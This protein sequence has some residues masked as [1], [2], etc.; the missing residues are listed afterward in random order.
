MRGFAVGIGQYFYRLL[1]GRCFPNFMERT[2]L[3]H[4]IPVKQARYIFFFALALPLVSS[5]QDTVTYQDL[6][7]K[8]GTHFYQGTPF[9]GVM[10]DMRK[11]F[12]MGLHYSPVMYELKAGKLHGKMR[13]YHENGGMG[14]EGGYAEGKEQ[15]TWKYY[16]YRGNVTREVEWKDGIM[17]NY[18]SSNC[19]NN[20][21]PVC[22]ID[23]RTYLNACWAKYRRIEI[24][25][26]DACQREPDP[27]DYLTWPIQ[28]ICD[29]IGRQNKRLMTLG[30]GTWLYLNK[31]TQDTIRGN[32]NRCKCLPDEAPVSTP[33]GLVSVKELNVGDTVLSYVSTMDGLQLVRLPVLLID[34]V[35]VGDDHKMVHL[36]LDDDRQVTASPLHPLGETGALMRDVKVGDILNGSSVIGVALLDYTG[37]YTR[38]ILTDG[39][40][41]GYLVNGVWLRSTIVR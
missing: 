41:G 8:D 1:I 21:D 6:T 4:P 36:M 12:I 30:D 22:G 35:L 26:K 17:V 16:E 7:V 37:Q 38:D 14:I 3:A 18:S 29:P 13:G 15:G 24:K 25:H 40:W 33:T 31:E 23:G 39:F 28:H 11:R 5:A 2:L 20:V 19:G 9:T 10:K 32:Q 34:S 27:T